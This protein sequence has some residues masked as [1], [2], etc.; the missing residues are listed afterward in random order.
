MPKG[1]QGICRRAAARS[2]LRGAE[3]AELLHTG[4]KCRALEAQ[5]LRGAA[6][7]ADPPA[8]LLENGDDVL[9][10]DAFEV[11]VLRY[12]T[13]GGLHGNEVADLEAAL[14]R[15]DDRALDD[16]LEL[17]HV[18]GPGVGAELLHEVLAH[19]THV[20]P[21]LRR[22]EHGEM[23]GEARDILQPFSQGRDD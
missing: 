3:D 12:R 8:G 18:P 15:E 4:F 14:R 6:L 23:P 20:F 5:D 19:R 9:A 2:R 16:V 22:V 21:H 17:P 11:P 1:W 7:A 10:L 13:R